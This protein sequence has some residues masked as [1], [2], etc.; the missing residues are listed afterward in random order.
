MYLQKFN[1]KY[2]MGLCNYAIFDDKSI[3]YKVL[4]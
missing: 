2:I 1:A 3:I 4:K